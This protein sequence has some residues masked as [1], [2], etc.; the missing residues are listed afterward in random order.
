M[1]HALL[2][3]QVGKKRITVAAESVQDAWAVASMFDEDTKFGVLALP[4][5]DGLL[6]PRR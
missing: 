2:A 4:C 3:V 6:N 5:C 1:F